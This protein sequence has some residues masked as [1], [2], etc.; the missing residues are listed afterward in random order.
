MKEGLPFLLL[1]A[2]ESYDCLVAFF[3]GHVQ[4]SRAPPGSGLL[5][6]LSLQQE[7]HDCPA[8]IP[9]GKVQGSH[10]SPVSG[11]GVP[12]GVQDFMASASPE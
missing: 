8:A 10:A 12:Q 11:S 4:G 9:A 2:E 6:C 5:V 7:G 3:A 1:H